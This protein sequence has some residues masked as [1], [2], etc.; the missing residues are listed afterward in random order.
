MTDTNHGATAREI[1]T[2]GAELVASL[3]ELGAATTPQVLEARGVKRLR[4]FTPAELQRL[5]TS[6]VDRALAQRSSDDARHDERNALVEDTTQ[7][8]E[9]MSDLD[10]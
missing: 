3:G 1:G 2:D 9:S 8:V 6:A 4:E 7:D 5:V 10:P